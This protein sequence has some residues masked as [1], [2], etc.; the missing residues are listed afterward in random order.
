MDVGTPPEGGQSNGA[1]ILAIVLQVKFGA[2]DPDTYQT[3]S[4]GLEP[5]TRTIRTL[6][7][8]FLVFWLRC[9]EASLATTSICVLR[10]GGAD[11][12][13]GVHFPFVLGKL[14]GGIGILGGSDD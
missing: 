11:G 9:H 5:G 1:L 10:T 14:N 13:D 12:V 4:A 8:Q 3:V 2:D 6:V 7:R